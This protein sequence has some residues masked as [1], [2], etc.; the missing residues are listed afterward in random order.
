ML[1]N[2]YIGDKAFYKTVLAIAVP[3][4][5]QNAISNF[6]GLLD[7]LMIGRVGTNALS[8][9]AIANQLIFIYYLL[10]FGAAAG[11][12]IFTAQYHGVGDTDGIRY[13][14]RMKI[15]A[16]TLITIASVLI[17]YIFGDTL[18]SLFLEGEGTASDAAETLS[19]GRTYMNIMLIGLIPN[20]WTQSYASTLRETGETKVPMYASFAAVFIN[21]IGNY[22]LIYG[23][24]GF[25]A[26]G[27]AGAA[28]A[29]IISR[30]IELVILMTYTGTHAQAHPFITGAL[31][32]MY[33][34]GQL[35]HKFVIK[36]LPLMI[37]EGLWSG[38]MTILNQCYSYRSLSAVAAINIQNTLFNLMGVAF[39]TMGDAVGILVGQILGTGDMDKAKDHARK[40]TAFTVFCG[41]IF[42]LFMIGL[43]PF[44]PQLYNTSDEIRHMATQFIIIA[45]VLM[46]VNAYAHATYFIIRAGGRTGITMV[47][48]SC[49]VW[50]ISVPLAFFLSRYTDL[51]VTR[52]LIIIQSL[53][54]IK[55][56][57]GGIMV[58]KGIWA[59]NLIA[60][61]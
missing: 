56:F 49:F 60:D 51:D 1:K 6:V 38:G 17:L 16:N 34:P 22:I 53:E 48:D 18:I 30:F 11:I 43:S 42:G 23:H 14:F 4:M 28:Y 15:L 25:P 7:N 31:K 24:L 50:V 3:I 35:V 32:S 26:L 59:R 5:I 27:A 13:T 39:L 37:N 61:A 41:L 55:C 19:I 40:L 20:A 47:F 21:L 57:I 29:T 8:G 58:K 9:V 36:A 46:P 52:M 45:G 2:K 10:V 33:I 44:F 12:G 54:I